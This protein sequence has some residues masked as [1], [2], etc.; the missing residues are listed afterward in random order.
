MMVDILKGLIYHGTEMEYT[1]KHIKHRHNPNSYAQQMQYK[2][3][4]DAKAELEYP[5]SAAG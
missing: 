1:L 4:V 2:S 5:S 3:E